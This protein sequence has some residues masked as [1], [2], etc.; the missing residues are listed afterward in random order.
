MAGDQR[1]FPRSLIELS[2]KT[3]TAGQWVEGRVLDL[4]VEGISLEVPQA[5]KTGEL[6]TIELEHSDL[7]KKNQVQAEVLR[8]DSNPDEPNPKVFHVVARLIEPND[9]YLMG[10]LNL[11]HGDGPKKDRRHSGFGERDDGR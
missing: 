1:K 11:V 6:T 2:A 9:E 10:A 4:S 7:M 5:L 3:Q 8:C